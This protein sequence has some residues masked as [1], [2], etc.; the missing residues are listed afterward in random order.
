LRGEERLKNK[1]EKSGD[2]AAQEGVVRRDGRAAKIVSYSEAEKKIT[3]D[4][5]YKPKRRGRGE[6]RRSN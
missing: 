1:Q 4:R 6:N 5:S 2:T 3:E